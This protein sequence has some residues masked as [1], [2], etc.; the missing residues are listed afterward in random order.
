MLPALL[1]LSQLFFS[2][3]YVYY[4]R[5]VQ[6][7]TNS[8]GGRGEGGKKGNFTSERWF[9]W[10]GVAGATATWFMAGFNQGGGRGRGKSEV[11]FDSLLSY[12]SACTTLQY[13]TVFYGTFTVLLQYFYSTLHYF[14]KVMFCEKNTNIFNTCTWWHSV[15]K[16]ELC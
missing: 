3:S 6:G 5:V 2:R 4:S 11:P 10:L 16:K 15:G 8:L 1:H 7:K 13:F 14:K 9:S 12:Y